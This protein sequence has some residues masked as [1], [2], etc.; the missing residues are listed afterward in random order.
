MVGTIWGRRQKSVIQRGYFKIAD[1]L[2]KIARSL[3]FDLFDLIGRRCVSRRGVGGKGDNQQSGGKKCVEFFHGF[4]LVQNKG[5]GVSDGISGSLGR[6]QP[7]SPK[8]Y[9]AKCGITFSAKS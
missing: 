8:V 1:H 4:I 6:R 9:T 5:N 7:E 2:A 3:G